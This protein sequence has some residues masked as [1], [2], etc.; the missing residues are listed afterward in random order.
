MKIRKYLDETSIDLDLDVGESGLDPEM[1]PEKRVRILKERTL[2]RM[3][4]LLDRSG[5]TGKVGKLH[6]DLL[7]REKKATTA[8]GGGIAMP[9]VRS[10]QARGLVIAVA[11]SK[12]GVDFGAP[13]GVPVRIFLSLVAPAHDD[14]LY[15]R[16]VQQLAELFVEEPG[17]WGPKEALLHADEPEDVFWALSG[18]E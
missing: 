6:L 4:E 15:L 5:R 18:V 8:L 2:L 16:V 14:R 10:R 11:V 7:N 3:A 1:A 13:D 12:E 9:H 17:E